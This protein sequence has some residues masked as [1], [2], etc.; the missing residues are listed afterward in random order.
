MAQSTFDTLKQ[1]YEQGRI[2]ITMLKNYVKVGKI[3][4]EEFQEITGQPYE[5]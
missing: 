1:R 4:P 2:D 5:D 3:T